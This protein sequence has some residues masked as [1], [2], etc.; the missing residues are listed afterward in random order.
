MWPGSGRRR[1]ERELE[2]RLRELDRWDELYGLGGVPPGHEQRGRTTPWRHHSPE[3]HD[4]LRVFDRPA[5]VAAPRRRRRRGGGWLVLLLL[6]A[7][8]VGAGYAYP[9]HAGT[10]LAWGE[11]A[12]R[13]ILGVPEG[14]HPT[15]D[16]P[17]I[18]GIPDDGPLA[19]EAFD[20]PVTQ[21]QVLGAGGW[22]PARGERVLPPVDPGVSG[23][24]AFL[25]TQPADGEPVGFSPCG[26]VPVAVNLEGAPDGAEE[27][28]E[29]SLAR[30]TAA[31]GLQLELVG[32]STA[33]WAE[34]PDPG[35][36][37]TISWATAD[38]VPELAG[39][40]AGLGGALVMSSPAGDAWA[41]SGR[42]V[43]DQELSHPEATAVVLD[44]ELGHVLGL[45]HVDDAGELMAALN[46]GQVGFGPGDLEGL[47]AL[48]AI[49][50]P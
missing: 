16:G 23:T 46:V 33:T 7:G 21:V 2:R 9:Q 19:R 20:D 10:A 24:H 1:R 37:V 27:I 15:S 12:G 39:H 49:P 6:V 48:G 34:L 11:R 42:V 41:A 22:E 13:A 3:G 31:T 32:R 45:D 40:T 28:V 35:D 17:M 18:P 43:I 25:Q 50:C 8:L 30:L 14:G 44:H 36:P 47:A 26:T 29:A 5:A 4:A 38:E